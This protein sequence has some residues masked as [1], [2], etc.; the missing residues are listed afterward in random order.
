M[1]SDT[2][3]EHASKR[4][5]LS[6]ACRVSSVATSAAAGFGYLRRVRVVQP[7]RLMHRALVV[8]LVIAAGCQHQD[9]AEG[10]PRRPVDASRSI[11]AAGAAPDAAT[12]PPPLPTSDEAMFELDRIAASAVAYLHAHGEYP[13]TDGITMPPGSACAQPGGVFQ[14]VDWSV[15]AGWKDLGFSI[16]IPNHYSYT[17]IADVPPQGATATAQGD[18]DCDTYNATYTLTLDAT[19][20][21]VITPPPPN[22]R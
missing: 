16:G 15:L 7:L 13:P 17:Y 3:S 9:P 11:D 5:K 8:V 2:K 18:L 21:A 6:P 10:D 14:P 22:L 12:C 20:T 19:G 1:V 4:R